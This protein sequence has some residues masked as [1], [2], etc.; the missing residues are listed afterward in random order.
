M[1]KQA[2]ENLA[3]VSEVKMSQVSIEGT[4]SISVE[5]SAGVIIQIPV[6]VLGQ[7]GLY[8]ETKD[9]DLGDPTK[10]KFVDMILFD[11]EA[12]DVVPLFSVSIGYRDA[13]NDPIVWTTKEYLTLNN[14]RVHPR[15][16][17]KFFKLRFEDESPTTQ[18]RLSRMEFYGRLMGGRL[19]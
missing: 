19:H 3:T 10:D 17:A 12:D 4:V 1:A 11:I 13:L 6:L 5:D 14:P 8:V 18:W 2:M 15:I 16:T 7:V 9:L